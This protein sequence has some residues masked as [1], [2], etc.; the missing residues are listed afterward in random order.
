MLQ[1]CYFQ[2]L[3]SERANRYR[4]SGPK[5][6]VIQTLPRAE[7][8]IHHNEF[9]QVFKRYL[10]NFELYIGTESGYILIH[11]QELRG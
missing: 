4:N 1:G 8:K 5:P 9:T 3:G 10:L 11:R 7:K 2:V 6:H